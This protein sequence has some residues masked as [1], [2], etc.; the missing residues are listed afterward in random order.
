MMTFYKCF[1]EYVTLLALIVM[2]QVRTVMAPKVARYTRV[3][4]EDSLSLEFYWGFVMV[5]SSREK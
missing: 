3:Q 1:H 4:Y 2:L 5:V